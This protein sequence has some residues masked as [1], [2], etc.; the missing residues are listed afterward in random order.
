MG[1]APYGYQH[2][3]ID[4]RSILVPREGEDPEAVVEAFRQV[5]TFNQAAKLLNAP[6]AEPVHSDDG[7]SQSAI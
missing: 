5:G 2:E 3:M 7:R 6:A 4:G 1:R